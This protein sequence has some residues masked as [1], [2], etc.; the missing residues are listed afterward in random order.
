MART[1][2]RIK[3]S[4][5]TDADFRKLSGRAQRLYLLVVSQATVNL[6]GVLPLT[7]TKWAG[8][9][10]DETAE[11]VETALAEL[12][13]AKFV[14][15]DRD[16]QEVWIR[17]F[18]RHDGVA[19]SPRTLHTA[20][21]QVG[22][23]S[24]TRIRRLVTKELATHRATW[25]DPDKGITWLPDTP[26]D[27]PSNTESDTHR[28]P[29]SSLQSPVTTSSLQSPPPAASDSHQLDANADQ[30]EDDETG[31]EEVETET[32]TPVAD[33]ASRISALC[34]DDN[35]R[36]KT[37]ESAAVAHWAISQVDLRVIEEAI[38]WF[39]GP[40]KTRPDRPHAVAGLIRSKARDHDFLMTE[41]VM[42]GAA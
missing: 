35:P 12:E 23:I 40:G 8:T 39:Y 2:S 5:W 14:V 17:S 6:C 13:A 33:I 30:P 31:I 16:E 15:V 38:N 22:T 10:T 18:V 42:P 21:G 41:F 19:R 37:L 7:T 11:S 20:R 24:S 36:R 25:V 32:T 29:V 28:A 26:S 9:A 1:E 27:T 34:Q 4:I 3:V